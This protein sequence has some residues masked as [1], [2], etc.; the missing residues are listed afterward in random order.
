MVSPLLV[1]FLLS[2][3]SSSFFFVLPLIFFPSSTSSFDSLLTVLTSNVISSH[4]T[5]SHFISSNL[6]SCL[7]DTLLTCSTAGISALS[8]PLASEKI[9]IFYLS[10]FSDDFI[11]VQEDKLEAALRCLKRYFN[12]EFIGA[13]E[14]TDFS[15]RIEGGILPEALTFQRDSL[16]LSTIPTRIFLASLSKENISKCTKELLKILL[17]TPADPYAFLS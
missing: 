10:T 2:S 11:L 1:L 7:P 4:L 13:D 6:V 12:V 9:S 17:Y 5:S 14:F 3:R 16:H 15:P 8:A